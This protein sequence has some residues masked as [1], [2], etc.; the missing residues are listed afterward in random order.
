MTWRRALRV[1]AVALPFA[2]LADTMLGA[3]RGFHEMQ[4]TVVVDRIGRST[5]QLVGV[6]SA[7]M[8]S[9]S[10]MLAPLWALP[11]VPAAVIS[12]LWLR[13]IMR[14]QRPAQAPRLKKSVQLPAGS[15]ESAGRS[16]VRLDAA[17]GVRADNQHGKPNARGF[18]RFTAPRSLASVAQIVIQRLDI[19]LVGI[20]KG[21]VEAAI[22]TAATR[23][24]VAGQL[25]NSAISMAAQPQ[26][27]RLF[28]IKDRDGA[29]TVYQVTTAWLILLT[30]PI[31][32]LAVV[33]GPSVLAIFGR[34]Y[35]AGSTVMLILALSMLVA[36]ACG[37]VDV[38]LITTGRSTWS[39]VNGLLA[40][41]VNISVDLI[42]IPRMGITGAAIGWAAAI[43]VSNLV[44]L[45]QVAVA[46][47]VHPF[48]RGMAAACALTV[49][50]FAV[51]PLGAA[52]GRRATGQGSPSQRRASEWR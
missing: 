39:L 43:V 51:V 10:A 47:K 25:G 13:R 23:F 41:C 15:A 40:M 30:W 38:V 5:L 7:A 22:Y 2:A 8:V 44:P 48:G 46:A 21:P 12:V 26:L 17:D 52:A 11:Y 6:I 1:L 35:H 19:V 42:L 27:T 28:A 45:V 36:T 29:N 37:Q 18:W 34:N 4:P 50:S 24:L 31:Y 49:V 16:P 9:T 20:M 32:L 33:F 3:S 14:E